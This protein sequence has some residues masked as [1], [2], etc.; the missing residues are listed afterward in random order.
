LDLSRFYLGKSLTY[1]DDRIPMMARFRVASPIPPPTADRYSGIKAQKNIPLWDND[2]IGNCT[3]VTPA[4]AIY[5][6]TMLSKGR[7]LTVPT[8]KVIALYEITGGYNPAFPGTDTGGIISQV[9]VYL[10]QTGYDIGTGTNQKFIS[11]R[12]NHLDL[13]EIK[14]CVDI[15]GNANWGVNLPL[16]ARVVDHV[17]DVPAGGVVTRD[18]VPGG[19]G[20]HNCLIVGYDEELFYIFTWG[21]VIAATPAFMLTYGSEAYWQADAAIELD[22]SGNTF[23]GYNQTSLIAALNAMVG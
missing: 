8:E 21:M 1:L 17:W 4:Q 9:L 6:W 18:G 22:A 14:D 23:N 3:C 13:D 7:A 19:W 12:V 10:A 16:A 15:G 2:K 5:Q 20:G 11:G